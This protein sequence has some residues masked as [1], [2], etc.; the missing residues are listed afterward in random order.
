MRNAQTPGPHVASATLFTGDVTLEAVGESHYQD[1]LWTIVGGRTADYVRHPIIAALVPEFSNEHDANA[2]VVQI[3]AHVVGYLSREDAEAYRP[4]ILRIMNETDTIVAL[5]GLVCGGGRRADG[6]GRLGVF[7]D[8][9]PADFG[10]TSS[11]AVRDPDHFHHEHV[12]TGFSEAGGDMS[13][14]ERLPEADRPAI[15]ALRDV[16]A[17]EKSAT[18]RHYMRAELERRLYHARDL[19]AEALAEFDQACRAHDDEMVSIRPALVT[20]FGGVPMLLT[21][22]QMCIRQSKAKQWPEAERWAARGLEVY[23]DEALREEAIED[24]TKRLNQARAKLATPA[25]RQA[26]PRTTSI[27]AAAAK[28]SEI[29]V[30]VC[31]RCGMSFERVVM[32]GRKPLLCPACRTAQA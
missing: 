6:I 23:G 32:R 29:E 9:D 18:K 31:R 24:L 19:Y 22:R 27:V 7:L 3:D 25:P 14:L 20:M 10:V 21:Y 4:A 11:H 30:L 15:T 8:H 2:V 16:I 17:N 26:A 5:N 1:A 28:E 13:W 12:R